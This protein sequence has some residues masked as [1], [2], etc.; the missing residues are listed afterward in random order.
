MGTPLKHPPVYFTL[1]QV[2][3]NPILKLDDFIPTVQE[4]FRRAGYPDFA[5]HGGIAIKISMQGGTPKPEPQTVN[6]YSFGD[7]AKT[8]NFVMTNDSLTLQSTDYGTFEEFARKFEEGLERIHEAVQLDFVA[9]IGLRYLDR[10]APMGKDKLDQYLV[11]QALGVRDIIGGEPL[12]SYCETLA[13]RAS[14]RLLSRVFTQFG[15]LGF[16]PDIGQHGLLLQE[17]FNV[18]PSLHAVLD[19]DGFIEQRIRYSIDA[20]RSHLHELHKFIGDAFKAL[21]TPYAFKKWNE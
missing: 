15:P 6:S 21:A 16:P 3:F 14:A 20:V 2:K 12:H 7:S 5:T 8:H 1:A 13:Q 19:T 10:V 18:E 4:A 17:R 11:P 9:R